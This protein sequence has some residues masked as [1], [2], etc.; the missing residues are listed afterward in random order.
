ACL[1]LSTGCDRSLPCRETA[2][3][4]AF[5]IVS[6]SQT[7][8]RVDTFMIAVLPHSGQRHRNASAETAAPQS[9]LLSAWCIRGT[10]L[11]GCD[12]GRTKPDRTCVNNTFALRRSAAASVSDG[13]IAC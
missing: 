9:Q 10:L 8:A 2:L 3:G 6:P 5:L 7:A 1:A 11:S 12:V 4:S 13:S